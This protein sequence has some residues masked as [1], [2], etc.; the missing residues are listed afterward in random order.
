MNEAAGRRSSLSEVFELEESHTEEAVGL[1]V[2]AFEPDPAYRYFCDAER[3]GYRRRLGILFRSGRRLQ[4]ASGQPVLGV[5]SGQRLAGLALIQEPG[6][7][8][9]V[10][11]Q[12]RWLTEMALRMGPRVPWRILRD[13]RVAE[14]A[15]PSE[16]HFY[17]P[18]LAVHPDFQGSGCGRVLLESLQARSERHPR[19]AGVC[20]ETENPDNVR[21]YEHIGYRVIARNRVADLEVTT[22]FRAHQRG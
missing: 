2:L 9:P 1:L 6:A 22:L 19:S 12:L 5:L 14:A 10:R 13:I 7:S 18:I 15:R 11:A 16:P 20:L 17:L 21:F 8:A 4:R 3:P